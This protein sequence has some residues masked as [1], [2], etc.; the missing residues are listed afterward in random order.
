[1][2][3]AIDLRYLRIGTAADLAAQNLILPLGYPALEVD[4]GFVKVGNGVS[5]YAA[6]SYITGNSGNVAGDVIWNAVGD[7]AVG[8][9]PDSAA[10]LPKGTALQVLRVNAAATALEWGPSGTGVTTFAALTDN[11]TA[12]IPGTNTATATALALKAPLA[13]PN[14]TGVPQAPTA[15]AGNSTS[16]LATTAYVV[17]ERAAAGTLTNKTMSGASNTFSA[18]PAAGIT[19]VIP[20]ANLATGT[21]TGSKFIRDDGTLQ[22]IAGGGDALIANPLS[23][24]AATTS[25]QLKNTISDETGS[26]ALVFATTPT[27]V[28][29]ALGVATATSI[30]KTAFTA[31]ATGSTLA[32]ADGKTLTASNTLTLTGTDGSSAAFG[33]GG[34]VAY[35]GTDLSQFAATTSAQLKTVISDETG[36]GALVFGTGPVIAAPTVTGVLTVGGAQVLTPAAMGA[37]AIDVASMN[38]TK[39][40]AVDSTFTFT[41]SPSTG[42]WFGLQLTNTDTSSHLISLPSCVDVNSGLAV[43]TSAFRMPAS[44]QRDLLWKWDG[45]VYRFYNSPSTSGRVVTPVSANG[46]TTMADANNEWTHPSADT[47]ARTWTIDSN[48]NVAYPIGTILVFSNQHSGGVITLAATSD[49]M[50]LLGTGTTGNRSIAADGCAVAKKVTATVWQVGG[51]GVT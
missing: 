5:T 19:G 14:F 21:P 45:A 50:Y 51:P 15:V 37:L 42:Q 34:I 17:N 43:T 33:A 10:V 39:S 8:N 3:V 24:F 4:T 41:G 9:G 48:A 18:L 29:P 20:I 12:D 49:T 32:V 23:Q 28:T 2:S 11:I 16:Q 22:A 47:T 26:G 25:L 35:K 1:M 13:A 44:A 36:S 40:I 38:N 30:N 31:P 7:L 6:L 27:L 46:T